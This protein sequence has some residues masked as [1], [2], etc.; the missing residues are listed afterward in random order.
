MTAAAT[1][2]AAAG[3]GALALVPIASRPSPVLLWNVSQSA[4][5]GLYR[6][7]PDASLRSG[8][9][10]AAFA[11]EEIRALAAERGYVPSSVPLVKR[12]AAAK[13]D[14]VC[15]SGPTLRVNGQVMALRL[16]RDLRGRALP[17]WRGCR[18]LR[19]GELLLLGRGA[20]SFDGRYFG[21]IGTR[22]LVGKVVLLW[23]P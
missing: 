10:V 14:L 17:W 1:L 4:P 16:M 20:N 22:A 6:V 15:A 13:G 12:L 18:R 9:M 23:R 7:R 5:I 21:P 8:D 3:G 19:G 11:P 2:C